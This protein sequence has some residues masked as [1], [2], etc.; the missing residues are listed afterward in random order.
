[1]PPGSYPIMIPS[2]N[3]PL[4]HSNLF[5]GYGGIFFPLNLLSELVTAQEMILVTLSSAAVMHI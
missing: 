2:P 4:A 5:C 3:I 1:M